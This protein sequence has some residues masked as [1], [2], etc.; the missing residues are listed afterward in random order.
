MPVPHDD[1]VWMLLVVVAALLGR[2]VGSD[3]GC[4]DEGVADQ[5]TMIVCGDGAHNGGRPL[6]SALP[7]GGGGAGPA[8]EAG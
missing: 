2:A 3:A 1:Q 7:V 4:G 8:A 5:L 6:S